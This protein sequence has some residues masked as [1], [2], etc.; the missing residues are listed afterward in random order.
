M[1]ARTGEGLG[2]WDPGD[3]AGPPISREPRELV[4]NGT[5][6]ADSSAGIARWGLGG[7]SKGLGNKWPVPRN[8]STS[9]SECT[10]HEEY[11]ETYSLCKIMLPKP[12]L[13]CFNN[14]IKK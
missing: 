13:I 8:S 1:A 10:V 11:M 7:F 4:V 9:V 14:S 5:V 2:S 3:L 6:T 12:R